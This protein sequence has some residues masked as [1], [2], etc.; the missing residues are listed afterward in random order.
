M[1]NKTFVVVTLVN[2]WK[3][4]STKVFYLCFRISYY[5]EKKV[6]EVKTH[7]SAKQRI[8]VK[9]DRSVKVY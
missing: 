2:S 6:Q 9:L 5:C 4:K 8:L 3:Y 1:L 7:P